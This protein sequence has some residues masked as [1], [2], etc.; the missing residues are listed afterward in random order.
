VDAWW[1]RTIIDRPVVWM[2]LPKATPPVPWP[3]KKPW[4]TVRDRWLDAEW[5]A[6]VAYANA[7]NTEWLG[8]A[9]PTWSPNL[10]PEVFSALFGAELEFSEDSSWSKPCLARWEDAGLLEF[11]GQNPWWSALHRLTEAC[12]TRG[13]GVFWTG[14]TDW[15]PGGDAVAA[16]RDP[17]VLNEDMIEHADDVRRLVD[18]VTATFFQ[19]YDHFAGRLEAAHQ[20]HTNWTRIV[21]TR[22]HYVPSND[23]SCMISPAMFNATFLPG[24]RAECQHLDRSLYHLDGPDALR[25]LGALLGIP[26]LSALQWVP[27][28][29][30]GPA[31]RWMDVYRKAQSAGKAVQVTGVTPAE[32][33]VFIE[34]LRP[35][36]VW[37]D[38]IDLKTRAEADDVLRQVEDWRR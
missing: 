6:E 1:D 12:L 32:V 20:P 38:V 22:R 8:D 14:M 21:S 5:N 18:R 2:T 37:L 4:P 31:A 13:R 34:A 16:F 15:H 23:F 11:S 33:P 25:H 24:L 30:K 27:G 10:G 17:E 35:E 3:A 7:V 9:V 36:G 29:G 28:A 19:V 26:E